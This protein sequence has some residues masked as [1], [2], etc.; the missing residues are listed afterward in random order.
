MRVRREGGGEE[1]K[2]KLTSI[3]M[4]TL[5]CHNNNMCFLKFSFL[6]H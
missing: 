4:G 2:D 6:L 1:E 5:F 3:D